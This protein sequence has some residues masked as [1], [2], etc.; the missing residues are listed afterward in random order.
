MNYIYN[1]IFPNGIKENEQ[2][3][4]PPLHIHVSWSELKEYFKVQ[5]YLHMYFI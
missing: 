2:E 1:Y 3:T 4:R 5:F